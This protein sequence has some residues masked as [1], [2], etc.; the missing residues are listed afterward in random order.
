MLVSE[1][2]GYTITANPHL[3]TGIVAD[4][5]SKHYEDIIMELSKSFTVLLK[6]DT[7]LDHIR[8]RRSI[9]FKLLMF[10]AFIDGLMQKTFFVDEDGIQCGYIMEFMFNCKIFD[11]LSTLVEFSSLDYFK[12][13]DLKKGFEHKLPILSNITVPNRYTM[14][15]NIFLD[16]VCIRIAELLSDSRKQYISSVHPVS[17]ARG[18][19]H[20]SKKIYRPR[21]NSSSTHRRRPSRKSASTKR[22]RSRR[23]HRR[24]SRK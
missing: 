15:C 13:L 23:P 3:R 24:T 14:I 4:Y 2:D 1:R 11:N 10:L 19:Q 20:I 22:R 6:T 5:F 8:N 7:S 18:G 12:F 16:K 17:S 9:V 21:R